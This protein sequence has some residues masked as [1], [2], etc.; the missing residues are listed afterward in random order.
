RVF[1]G[2][3]LKRSGVTDAE[4]QAVQRVSAGIQRG[5][6]HSFNLL[7]I[8]DDDVNGIVDEVTALVTAIGFI[9][10]VSVIDVQ[11]RGA[12]VVFGNPQLY[13]CSHHTF[14]GRIGFGKG[15]GH[16]RAE[17]LYTDINRGHIRSAAGL[18]KTRNG[19]SVGRR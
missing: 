10:A 19:D 13:Q 15:F 17:G 11:I 3:A 8:T 7:D 6:D 5:I 1:T 14:D 9:E 4:V 18:T 2:F 16:V 12:D